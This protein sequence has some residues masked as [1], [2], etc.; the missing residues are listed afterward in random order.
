M[1]RRKYP[2]SA[3]QSD[4]REVMTSSRYFEDPNACELDR[5]LLT[6]EYAD[7]FDLQL[8]VEWRRHANDLRL[9]CAYSGLFEPHVD[10]ETQAYYVYSLLA[11]GYAERRDNVEDFC[12]AAR[13]VATFLQK[14]RIF[15]NGNGNI[16]P[17]RTEEELTKIL[18]MGAAMHDVIAQNK[19]TASN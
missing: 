3:Q 12:D 11:V 19:P 2:T 10:D 6:D 17:G 16:P 9:S 14:S 18:L 15:Y 13:D 7:F 5:R 4:I 8:G 1:E